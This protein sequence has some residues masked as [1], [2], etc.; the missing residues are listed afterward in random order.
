MDKMRNEETRAAG[1][2]NLLNKYD[3]HS[4]LTLSR[5]CEIIALHKIHGLH[6]YGEHDFVDST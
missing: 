2:Q 3:H 1:R 6:A 5:T 4:S